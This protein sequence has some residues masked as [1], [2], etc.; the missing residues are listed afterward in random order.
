MKPFVITEEEL[1]NNELKHYGI[2]RRSGRYPWGSGDNVADRSK[3]FLD[4]FKSM[5][6]RGLTAQEAAEGIGMTTTQI[7]EAKTIAIAEKKASDVAMAHRL[8]E[9]GLSNVEIGKRLGVGEGTVRNLLKPGADDKARIIATTTS[10]LRD[11]VE[12]KDFVDVGKGVEVS[13]GISKEKL[14]VALAILKDEGYNVHTVKET[15]LGTGKETNFKVLTKPE[16]TQNEVWKNRDKIEQWNID[17]YSDDGGRTAFGILPPMPIDPS[18]V[19]V[20]YAEDGGIDADGVLYVR[21]G[22]EDVSFGAKNYAQVRVQVGDGHYMK[23]MAVYKDDLPDGVDIVFNTNK[24]REKAPD[25]MDVFKALKDDPDNPFG[26]VIKRQIIDEDHF[27]KTGEERLSSSMNILNEEGD[28]DTWSR[29]LS[30]QML[31]KQ[32]HKLA[33]QQLDVYYERKANDLEEIMAMNNPVIKRM[34]LDQFADSADSASVHMKAAGF[35]GQSTHVLLP[36][37][38]KK[39]KVTEVYAPNFENGERVVLIRHPHGGVFEIPELVVNNRNPTAKALLGQAKDAIGINAKVAEQLSG[40]DF[41]G[42]TVLVIPNS[43]GQVKTAPALKEL[44]DF[45]PKASYPKYDGMKIMKNTGTQMGLISNLI[46]DMTILGASQEEIAAAVRHSMVVID[47]EKHELNWKQSEKDNGIRNLREKY[48]GKA[49]RGASTLISKASG[50]VRVPEYRLARKEEGGPI[51]PETGE[52]IYVPTGRKNRSGSDKTVKVQRLSPQAAQLEGRRDDAF[53]LTSKPITPVEKVYATHSNKMK[54]LANTARKEM[55][56]TQNIPYNPSARRVYQRE[57][58]SLNAKLNVALKNKPLERQAQIV[59]N[60]IYRQK[61]QANPNMTDDEK[62]KAKSQALAQ[63]RARTGAKGQ[64][65]RVI[66]SEKEWEAVQAGAISNNRLQELI[67]NADLD[68]VKKLAAPRT[69]LTMT[70]TK[71][72]RARA[73]QNA[74]YT[75]AEIANALGVGL[76]TLKEGLKD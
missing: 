62:K 15:Q 32:H 50:D 68:E 69:A 76:T 11:S 74:G 41:D 66:F 58:D 49:N 29:T 55:L 27:K 44:K 31:T 2:L 43:R 5:L 73:M 36:I 21:P 47:A 13:L 6:D 37:D 28:W 63:A 71:L 59:G 54:A 56:A 64:K 34:M 38:P 67:N 9:K 18:R 60:T 51:N 45:D 46:T 16:I 61:V 7:R 39:M 52:K 22:V 4:W 40:A 75:Q 65:T 20:N 3:G 1:D 14:G 24:T 25:K 10:I 8:K 30:T 23:G 12:K 57:V 19:A 53:E 70:S 33:Q 42:D 26:A 35:P 48:L 17:H 72:N